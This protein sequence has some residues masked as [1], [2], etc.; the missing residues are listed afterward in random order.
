MAF[1]SDEKWVHSRRELARSLA[2]QQMIPNPGGPESI[3]CSAD[4]FYILHKE[5]WRVPIIFQEV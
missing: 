5:H 4:A 1:A 3:P 2:A